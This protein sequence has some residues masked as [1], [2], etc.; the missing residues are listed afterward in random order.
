MNISRIVGVLT[1]SVLFVSQAL[2][3]PATGAL[4]GEVGMLADEEPIALQ[5]PAAMSE[6][7]RASYGCFVSG[8]GGTTSA[9]LVGPMNLVNVVAGGAAVPAGVGVLAMGLFGVVFATFCTVGQALTPMVIDLSERLAEPVE[10][11]GQGVARSTEFLSESIAPAHRLWRDTVAMISRGCAESQTC[12]RLARRP[13]PV[14]Q[15]LQPLL[16]AT[17]P[18]DRF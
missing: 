12:S 6:A 4:N 2:A 17:A 10:Q 14:E 13:E 18:A 16:S 15:R 3:V 8:I 9:F 11:A 1:A 5:Q 7:V